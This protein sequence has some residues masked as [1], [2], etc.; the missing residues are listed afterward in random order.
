MTWGLPVDAV[1]PS[2]AEHI[3]QVLASAI[4][5]PP[6]S[7]RPQSPLRWVTVQGTTPP[8]SKGPVKVEVPAAYVKASE[9]ADPVSCQALLVAAWRQDRSAL[10]SILLSL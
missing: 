6:R 8:D 4:L 1:L 2:Q 10:P 9:R 5:H 7:D 3:G